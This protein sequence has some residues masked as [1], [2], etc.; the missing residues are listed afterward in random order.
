MD[1]FSGVNFFRDNES[2]S[3]D[4][5]QRNEVSYFF[6]IIHRGEN[7][8]FTFYAFYSLCFFLSIL[9]LLL[10]AHASSFVTESNW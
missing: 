8:I 5:T 7:E 3:V 1:S 9:L 2:D 6:T 4:L 10:I